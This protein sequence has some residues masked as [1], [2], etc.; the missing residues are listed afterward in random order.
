MVTQSSSC[1]QFSPTHEEPEGLINLC[2][3]TF[4]ELISIWFSGRNE[5]FVTVLS[6]NY[7][8]YKIFQE[9]HSLNN[10][11]VPSLD[12]FCGFFLWYSEIQ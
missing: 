2:N 12:N 11:E 3:T 4:R 9:G 1:S 6:D 7:C 10:S 8:L 5:K